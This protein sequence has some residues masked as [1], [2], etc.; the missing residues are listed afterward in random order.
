M[1]TT[2]LSVFFLTVFLSQA[3]V[4]LQQNTL[5]RKSAP[6]EVPNVVTA[7]FNARVKNMI[8]SWTDNGETYMASYRDT[9][10]LG[11]I[12]TYDRNGAFI[13][14]QDEMG[15]TAYP[16]RIGRYHNKRYPDEKFTVW[17]TT[18]ASNNKMYYFTRNTETV[19]FDSK[20]NLVD[21]SPDKKVKQ[22]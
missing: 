17:L 6:E 21:K 18:D 1:K 9:L 5:A 20:G 8:P 14:Q 3:Q 12:F 15:R 16:A 4:T 7:H 22:P 10:N 19:W 2:A 13:S 11:H